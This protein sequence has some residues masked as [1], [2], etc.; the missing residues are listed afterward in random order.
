MSDSF[1]STAGSLFFAVWALIVGALTA[2]VFGRDLL[3]ARRKAADPLAQNPINLP[4]TG[5]RLP[6][7]S[8]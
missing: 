7:R 5:T 1:L 4:P 3:P 2:K 6:L 8:K